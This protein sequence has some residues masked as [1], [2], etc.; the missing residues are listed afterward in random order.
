MVNKRKHTALG[1]KKRDNLEKLR[2]NHPSLHLNIN[3]QF[4]SLMKT[5]LTQINFIDSN[6]HKITLHTI[7]VAGGKFIRKEK[8]VDAKLV[9]KEVASVRLHPQ[10]SINISWRL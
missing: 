6:I 3:F 9:T 5:S 7:L 10:V 2:K 1:I 8:P 4:F